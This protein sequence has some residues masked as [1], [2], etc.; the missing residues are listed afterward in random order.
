MFLV[1]KSRQRRQQEL[2][3][4]A[5]KLKIIIVNALPVGSDYSAI[6]LALAEVQKEIVNLWARAD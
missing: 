6:L 3:E 1:E 4:Q 2:N 5:M